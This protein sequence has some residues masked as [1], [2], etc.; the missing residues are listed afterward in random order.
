MK[1]KLA[2]ITKARLEIKDRG[3]LSFWIWV[4]YEEGC[5][6]GVG[7][8]ALD[9]WDEEKGRRVGTTF[10]TEVIRQLL[11]CVGVNDFSEMKGKYIW[12]LG[13]GDGL[14]FTPKGIKSLNTEESK[15]MEVVWEEILKILE[16]KNEYH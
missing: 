12:V 13:E 2:K 8:I 10:G 6:Q 11:I 15:G 4:D 9:T 16:K 3:I 1:K 14:S 5:S 7:G